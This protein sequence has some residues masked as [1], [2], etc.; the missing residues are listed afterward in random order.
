[1]KK[2][3]NTL[4]VVASI[5]CLLLPTVVHA[6]TQGA[7]TNAENGI[8]KELQEGVTV[9]GKDFHFDQTDITQAE[10]YLKVHDVSDKVAVEVANYLKQARTIIVDNAQNVDVQSVNSLKQLIKSLPRPVIDELKQIVIEIGK[11]LDLTVTFY[12]DGVT[13]VDSSGNPVYSTGN[14][15]KQTGGDYTMSAITAGA[16]AIVSVVAYF[17]ARRREYRV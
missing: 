11:L 4:C 17:V 14:A 1:M 15:I 7:I 12:R 10:N 16:L 9:K 8:L 5:L 6:D 2:L 3:K 13:I